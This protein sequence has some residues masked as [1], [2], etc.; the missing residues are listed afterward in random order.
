MPTAK[1]KTTR[2]TSKKTEEFTVDGDKVVKKVRS[3]LEEGHARRIIIKSE[4]GEK[5]LEIPVTFA[6]VGALLAP[7][8]AALGAM[9]ALVAKCTIVV[10]KK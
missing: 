8:L 9:A 2:R 5:L 6:A 1:K 7:I 3:I 4:T 10:Q